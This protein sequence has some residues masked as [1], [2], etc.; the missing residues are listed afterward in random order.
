MSTVPPARS[1]L[2]GARASTRMGTSLSG[3]CSSFWNVTNT[4]LAWGVSPRGAGN[5]ALDRSLGDRSEIR[6]S[7]RNDRCVLPSASRMLFRCYGCVTSIFSSI[8]SVGQPCLMGQK[9]CGDPEAGVPID[10]GGVIVATTVR[11]R[12][13]DRPRLPKPL[14]AGTRSVGDWANR[15]SRRSP[16]DSLSHL[17]SN[18]C[19]DRVH[20]SGA[21]SNCALIRIQTL[22]RTMSRFTTIVAAVMPPTLRHRP[23]SRSSTLMSQ[24][25]RTWIQTRPAQLALPLPANLSPLRLQSAALPTRGLT[26]RSKGGDRRELPLL[27][28]KYITPALVVRAA[29]Q[30]R[31]RRP[32]T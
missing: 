4:L 9:V 7:P 25:A 5:P 18:T 2:A 13:K 3:V 8:E 17:T 10:H 6:H 26:N 19:L 24:L 32:E 21:C 28:I 11:S 27:S 23:G 1:A 16:I 22:R 20:P 12:D 14:R 15:S 30:P 31:N 29:A